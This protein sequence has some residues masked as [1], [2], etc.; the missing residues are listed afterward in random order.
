MTG[1]GQN[2]AKPMA[3]NGQNVNF[4]IHL[5]PDANMANLQEVL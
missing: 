3:T 5:G 1:I 4:N 2:N